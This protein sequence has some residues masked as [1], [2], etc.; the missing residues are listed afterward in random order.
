MCSLWLKVNKSHSV[1]VVSYFRVKSISL[2][3]VQQ[4][5]SSWEIIPVEAVSHDSLVTLQQS[6]AFSSLQLNQ[7]QKA[8]HQ[9]TLI[10]C[11]AE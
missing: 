9:Y 10:S 1:S 4:L 3:C 2:L 7:Q 6:L 5:V 8:S 11:S